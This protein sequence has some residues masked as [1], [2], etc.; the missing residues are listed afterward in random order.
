MK[1]STLLAVLLI[2]LLMIGVSFSETIRQGGDRYTFS[3]SAMV[4]KTA[5]YTVTSAD[6]EIQVNATSGAV[7]ITLPSVSSS[8]VGGTK[9]Y[10][11]KKTDASTNVV[12]VTPATDNTIGGEST[13][14]LLY[15]NAYMVISTG[16]GNDWHVDFESPY[17]QED[18]EAGTITIP[19]GATQ[20]GATVVLEGATADDYEMTITATDPTADRTLTLPNRDVDMTA[21]DGQVLLYELNYGWNAVT[22]SGAL[23]INNAGVGSISA[24]YIT[25]SMIDNSNAD[26][27]I[28]IGQGSASPSWITMSSDATITAVGAITLSSSSVQASTLLTNTI[29]LVIAS[30]SATNS[31]AIPSN[32][33][34]LGCIPTNTQ[35]VFINGCTESSGTITVNLSGNATAHATIGLKM[36]MP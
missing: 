6:S 2:A 7:T 17:I 36:V 20:E 22:V 19:S 21:S 12:T 35:A 10:K 1:K 23:T 26:A 4:T 13:R 28:L 11:I 15:Q 16:P 32:A 25:A 33:L 14:K 9:A 29:S 27:Q 30:G 24:G 5:N 8:M 18:Y 34:F 31:V 3:P